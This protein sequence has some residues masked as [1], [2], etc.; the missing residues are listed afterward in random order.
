MFLR[1]LQT[2]ESFSIYCQILSSIIRNNSNPQF[3]SSLLTCWVKHL[4]VCHKLC[5]NTQVTR[6]SPLRFAQ[7]WNWGFCL[8]SKEAV[9]KDK[10]IPRFREK[11]NPPATSGVPPRA[12]CPLRRVLRWLEK[13]RS[14]YPL[15]QR[16]I[17]KERNCSTDSANIYQY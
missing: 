8:P 11:V 15:S 9:W 4:I 17:S 1:I 3:S 12:T 16:S 6:T 5:T 14:D 10:R 13:S 2:A 7:R